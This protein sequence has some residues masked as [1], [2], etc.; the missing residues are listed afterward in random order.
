MFWLCLDLD[1]LAM[2]DHTVTGFGHNRRAW[3]SIHDRDYAGPGP[4]SIREKITNRLSEGGVN[5]PLARITLYTLPRVCGYVFNPVSFYFC[6]RPDETLAAV[7]AEVHNTFG[8]GHHYVLRP[9]DHPAPPGESILFRAAKSFYVSPFLE[10]SGAYEVLVCERDD[11]L[12]L[13]IQ[14]EQ[15]GELMFTAA[16]TG[17][18]TPMSSRALAQTLLRLPFLAATIMFRIHWQ[19]LQLSFFK[20]LPVF[21]KPEPVT[22]GTFVLGLP[23]IWHRLRAL[24]VSRASRKQNPLPATPGPLSSTEQN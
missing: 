1:E 9:D 16:M 3:A 19:A 12:R 10:V 6:Y 21:A 8:E 11:G 24:V 13:Q 17:R 14:L 4:G 5:E 18:A 22:V 15:G 23:S 2:L 7:V 20:R